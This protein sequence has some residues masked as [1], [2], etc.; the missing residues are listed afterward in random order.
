MLF[1]TVLGNPYLSRPILGAN[2]ERF[3]LEVEHGLFVC[4]ADENQTEAVDGTFQLET[5][6]Q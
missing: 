1:L 5:Q 2:N 3:D 6:F 4:I